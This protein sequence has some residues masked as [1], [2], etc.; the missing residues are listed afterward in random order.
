VLLLLHL[1][2]AYYKVAVRVECAILIRLKA[3]CDMSNTS[4]SHL[5][6]RTST[7]YMNIHSLTNDSTNT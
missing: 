3:S 1:T 6:G 2:Y 7:G 5:P 4:K